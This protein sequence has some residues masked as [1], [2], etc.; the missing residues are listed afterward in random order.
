MKNLLLI[1]LLAISICSCKEKIEPAE[2]IIDTYTAVKDSLTLAIDSTYQQGAIVGFSVAIVTKDTTLYNKGFGHANVSENKAYTSQTIQNIGSVSKTFIGISLLKAQEMGKL[3][4]DDPI[5]KY[6]SFKVVNPNHPKVP[7]TIR[8]LTSHTSS[9]N[10]TDWYG[11]SYIMQ[12]K[13]H[14]SNVVIP[15]YFSGP[16]SSISLTDYLKKVLTPNGEWYEPEIFALYKPGAKYHYSNIGAAVAAMVIEGAT[17]ISFDTFTEE[18]IFKP[19]GMTA[20]GWFNKDI[21]ITNRSNAFKT[22]DTLIANY[23]LITYPDGGL[24][25]S[26]D[27]LSKYLSELMKGYA[28]VGTLLN[29]ESYQEFFKKQL[30]GSHFEDEK[31]DINKG[32]FLSYSKYGIGHSGGD[33]G[34]VT[35]MFFNPETS[36]GKIVF[37]NT[38]SDDNPQLRQAFGKVWKTLTA[39]ENKLN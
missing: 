29:K 11:K 10:D 12:E 7:I 15:D 21:D 32:I 24:I 31:L 33:P 19:M 34:I 9:I 17:E 20:T 4:L 3:N 26:T 38:D 2:Q 18:H 22:K 36:I 8:Q 6:L 27:N 37:I 13:E 1:L 30:V 16:E 5:N 14:T 25:T 39:Y 35:F 28:G 23:R